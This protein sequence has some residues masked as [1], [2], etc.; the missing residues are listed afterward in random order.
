MLGSV[1]SFLCLTFFGYFIV[2]LR[3][4]RFFSVVLFLDVEVEVYGVE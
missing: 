2:V 4:R 3:G 1:L